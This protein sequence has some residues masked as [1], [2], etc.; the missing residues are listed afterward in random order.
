M[1]T[2]K[3]VAITYLFFLANGLP[4]ERLCGVALHG[5]AENRKSE[6]SAKLIGGISSS[7]SERSSNY[8][9]TNKLNLR[10]R[11]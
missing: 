3:G 5:V 1:I 6:S 4:I 8:V 7:E 2:A 10:E 11:L 9:L